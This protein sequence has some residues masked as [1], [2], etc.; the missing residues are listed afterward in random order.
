MIGECELGDM[1]EI[2]GLF[3]SLEVYEVPAFQ[4]L[5]GTIWMLKKVNF[6]LEITVWFLDTREALW[7]LY[8]HVTSIH[9]IPINTLL[10][11]LAMLVPFQPEL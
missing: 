6:V 4:L 5:L 8:P 2:Y 3:T 9:R 11:V 1:Q 7:N 10:L